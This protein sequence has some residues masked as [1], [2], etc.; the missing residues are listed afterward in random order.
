MR[1]SAIRLFLLLFL[2][3][4]NFSFSQQNNKNALK[5]LEYKINVVLADK[6]VTK[7]KHSIAVWSLDKKAF[8]YKKNIET[9]LTPASTTKIFT[10]FCAL[11]AMGADYKIKTEI[12][13]DA[14]VLKN[15]VVDG[16]LY[17]IGKGYPLLCEDDI[18]YM[19]NYLKSIGINEITG[20]IYIDDTYFDKTMGRKNYSGDKDEVEPIPPISALSLNNNTAIISISNRAGKMTASVTPSAYPA[21]KTLLNVREVKTQ[22]EAVTKKNISPKKQTKK[23]SHTKVISKTKKN[24]KH[25]VSYLFQS[26]QRY[27]DA[28]P[29]P[30]I[31]YRKPSIS[32]MPKLQ[33]DGSQVFSIFGNLSKGQNLIYK[34]FIQNPALVVA[35]SLKNQLNNAGIKVNKGIDY[36]KYE[37]SPKFRITQPLTS[38]HHDLAEVVTLANKNS[39]NYLAESIFKLFGAFSG[40][41]ADCAKKAREQ[42][43]EIFS[44]YKI[45]SKGMV[46]NDGSGLSRRNLITSSALIGLLDAA[47][48]LNIF[49]TFENSLSIA[50]EDGTLRKR[51]RGTAA[52]ENVHAKTGTLKNA[53]SLTGYMIT[54][55]GERLAFA[56]M[57]NGPNVG[58]Y[59]KTEN[60]LTAILAEFSY[61]SK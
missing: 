48:K 35:T 29:A 14:Q 16:N 19:A 17:L 12:Y 22:K 1:N 56:F 39:D 49:D 3:I 9:P 52:E 44:R 5:D 2:F 61:I 51:M 34:C 60:K 8:L 42:E 13:T 18:K 41:S 27:G 43:Q 45:N 59:K 11:A 23:Q 4:Y 36:K 20:S 54:S 55:S 6:N 31:K 50:G 38:V 10:T 58:Y 33:T 30:K 40:G 28:P 57:F 53:S 47:T 37:K 26:Q 15:G 24:N 25:K 7:S 32:I 46:I 21:L